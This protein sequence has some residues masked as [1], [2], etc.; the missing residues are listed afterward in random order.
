MRT[1]S[2]GK[3]R[4]K[5]NLTRLEKKI[6]SLYNL[7]ADLYGPD[8]LVLR[9]GKLGAL[10]L[11]RSADP[12]ER[13]LGLQRL[14]YEDPTLDQVPEIAS[15]PSIISSLED[16]LAE[17]IARRTVED[18]L[19]KKIN[20]R[21]RERHED[22]VKEIRL[23]VMK[24]NSGPEN[25]RTLKKL[26][27]LEKMESKQLARTAMEFLRPRTLEEIVGQS[28]AVQALLAKLASPYPQHVLLYGPPGVGKTTAAR[29]ALAAARQLGHSPFAAD[30]PFVEVNGTTLR[31]DPREVTNPLLGSVHDPIYQGARRDLAE[32]GVP[33]PK[34]GL[35]SEAHGGVLFIDE[36]GEMDPLLQSKLLK[37]LEDKRVYFDSS[38]YDP[39]DPQVPSYVRKLFEEGAPADFILIGATTREPEEINPALRSRCAEIFFQPLTPAELVQIVQQA[40]Q[41]LQVN[42]KP[43]AAE[44]I[45]EYTIEG[46]KAINILADAYSLA[47]ARRKSGSRA[48]PA[49]DREI[50][51]QV[52]QAARL[53]PY[54]T[55]KASPAREVGKILG[56][57]VAGFLGTVLEFE[58]VAFPAA[59]SGQGSIRFN[60]TA[61]SMARDAVFNAATLLRSINGQD[62]AE[63]DLH[64]N[65][66]GGGRIDGPSAGL[67]L[68]LV[69]YSA[70]N[71]LP[72]PQDVAVTG[73]V[74]LRGRVRA[75]GGIAEKIYGARQA[76]VKR[77]FLP[78]ENAAEVPAGLSGI[79]VVP[80]QDV[81]QVLEALDQQ[82]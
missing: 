81:H 56:L 69:I 37:V 21:L 59:R 58:A 75:V 73:E 74:S 7:L 71:Q 72:L 47:L 4:Q 27:V 22:Y 11:M 43:G 51:S 15:I 31:W 54:V 64:I 79:Q 67:A 38:Y 9:G 45:A 50:V 33:E 17:I 40:A 52:L 42:L 66:V 2:A 48:R 36:I 34:L 16:E 55:T 30:A 1:S 35:V 60:E 10:K 25:A 23:Q 14:I 65:V 77:V 61:G 18:E 39:H 46:R 8:K 57:G 3:T 32:S 20:D 53:T 19:E 62:L 49:I 24:E 82:V 44:L 76:G 68:F 13:V 5:N 29:L 41:K 26:A 12:G 6:A 63:Y 28:Q 78:A 80:V 70:I